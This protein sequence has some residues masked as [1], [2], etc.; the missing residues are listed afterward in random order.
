MNENLPKEY[1]DLI[2]KVVREKNS[3]GTT[4]ERPLKRKRRCANKELP[5]VSVKP[6][7]SEPD[8]IINIDSESEK[9]DDNA[10]E[11]IIEETTDIPSEEESEPDTASDYDSDEFEDVPNTSTEQEHPIEGISV[12][13]HKKIEP[14][15]KK[16]NAVRNMCDNDEKRRRKFQHM[17]QLLC[18]MVHGSIRNTWLNNSKLMRKL[19][20]LVPDKVLELL[21]PKKDNEMILRSTRKL[22]D[23]LKQTMQIW[24]KHMKIVQKYHNSTGLYMKTWDEAMRSNGKDNRSNMTKQTFIKQVLKGVGDRDVATQGFVALLR[25]CNIN[26]RLIMSC[27]PCDFTNM[28]ESS[29]PCQVAYD[30]MIKFPIFWC[31]VWDKFSK[32]WI[33]I[34]PMNLKTIEQIKHYTKMEPRGV[35]CCKRNMIRYVIAYDRQMG[36]R[37]VTRRYTK[38]YNAKIRRKRITKDPEGMMWYNKVISTLHKRSRTKIDD[39]EDNYFEIRN[40]DEG[41]PDCLADMKSHPYY[42]LERD[43]HSNQVLRTGCKECGY[44]NL[45]NKGMIKVYARKDIIDLKSGRQWYNEG[46]ILKKGS[47]HLKVVRK[48]NREGE[49]EDERLYA[50]DS[51]EIYVPPLATYPLGEIQKNTFGN[52][53]IFVPSMIPGNC[54]L[55]ESPVA[56]KA[57][58]FIGIQYAPAVTKFKFERG[59]KAKVV[60]SGVVVGIWFKD[61]VVACIDGIEY[62]EEETK[63][64]QQE[65]YALEMWRTL[66]TKMR[67]KEDLINTYGTVQDTETLEQHE[68]LENEEPVEMGGGFFV[69]GS[70]RKPRDKNDEPSPSSSL[71]PSPAPSNTLDDEHNHSDEELNDEYAM[72]MEDI[73]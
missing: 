23:G 1:F 5:N 48:K 35:A 68:E 46:R 47:K 45:P 24:Q 50:I 30:D 33:S 67:I 2:R 7:T 15:T 25:S 8:V 16:K 64:Q 66:L 53:E 55:I 27:Q 58:K 29:D 26:A 28:K 36:C 61:A 38:W 69:T 4:N 11:S 14:I 63:R 18:L 37:D 43:L 52:I 9:E 73:A 13:I 72:F 71:K 10:K 57:C 44:L 56:I 51:T 6:V 32:Q 21:H 62:I 54:C 3:N 34:D 22:L 20:R 31:E 65:L 42:I 59:A 70:E 60:I 49:M 17:F 19:N 12:T 41:M 39:Y 40:E